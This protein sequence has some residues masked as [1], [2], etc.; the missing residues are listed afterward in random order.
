MDCC[1]FGFD[2]LISYCQTSIT[3]HHL[4]FHDT[5][6]LQFVNTEAMADT[7]APKDSSMSPTAGSTP[8]VTPKTIIHEY[9]L[10]RLPVYRELRELQRQVSL[11][12][13]LL[14]ASPDSK[15]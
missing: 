12:A 9:L 6:P 10:E 11:D 5:Y 14:P 13:P 15:R 3:N 8:K 4:C 2:A 7:S 1:Q